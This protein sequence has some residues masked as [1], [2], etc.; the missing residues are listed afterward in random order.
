M[1]A[2]SRMDALVYGENVTYCCDVPISS[3]PGAGT[4]EQQVRGR[5]NALFQQAKD[6]NPYSVEHGRPVIDVANE[7]LE[8]FKA[9]IASGAKAE[10]PKPIYPLSLRSK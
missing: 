8:K 3:A 1:T 2:R 6:G 5:I 7:L 10:V 4:P 9:H